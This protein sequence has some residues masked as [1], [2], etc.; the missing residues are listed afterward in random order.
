MT[1]HKRGSVPWSV[2]NEACSQGQRVR[3]RENGGP[4]CVRKTSETCT[5]P[6]VRRGSIIAPSLRAS[7]SALDAETEELRTLRRASVLNET[8]STER[9]MQHRSRTMSQLGLHPMTYG[10]P[11]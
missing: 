3:D 7:C 8:E 2:R 5:K 6:E 9:Q 4:C 11:S 1:G 10:P